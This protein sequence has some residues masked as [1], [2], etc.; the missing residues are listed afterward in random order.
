MYDW[1]ID[2]FGVCV[3]GFIAMDCDCFCVGY[4]CLRSGTHSFSH[5]PFPLSLLGRMWV[6]GFGGGD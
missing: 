2:I 6:L 3:G 1:G 5:P 4:I